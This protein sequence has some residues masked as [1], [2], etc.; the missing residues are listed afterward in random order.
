MQVRVF[1]CLLVI[2]GLTI[3][4]PTMNHPALENWLNKE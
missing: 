2:M 4:F 3:S 1:I